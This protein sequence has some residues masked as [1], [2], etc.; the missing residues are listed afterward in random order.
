MF[1]PDRRLP[2]RHGGLC[3][4]ADYA[5]QADYAGATGSTQRGG[6]CVQADYAAPGLR[7]A[8]SQADRV[9]VLA[10]AHE[11]AR[12]RGIATQRPAQLTDDPLFASVI[13]MDMLACERRAA[14]V[15]AA[16]AIGLQRT[17]PAAQ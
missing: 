8:S 16:M 3:G 6:L 11:L 15:G 10:V 4:V 17:D 2:E 1:A 5:A 7:G 14:A 9:T 13:Q 12:D